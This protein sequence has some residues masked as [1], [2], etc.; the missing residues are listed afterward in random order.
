MARLSRSEAISEMV[1]GGLLYVYIEN[2]HRRT[3]APKHPTPGSG[4]IVG[5]QGLSH[6]GR[7]TVRAIQR[8]GTTWCSI[9]QASVLTDDARRRAEH[10]PSP[11][12]FWA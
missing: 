6:V 12:W 2:E 11:I 4:A 10:G 9:N 3:D 1:N 8:L 7:R 5:D